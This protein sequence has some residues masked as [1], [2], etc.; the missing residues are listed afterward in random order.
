MNILPEN[1]LFVF[2]TCCILTALFVKMKFTF[3]VVNLER[4]KQTKIP[5]IIFSCR[6]QSMG[7]AQNI[8][9]NFCRFGS[10]TLN[11]WV[12]GTNVPV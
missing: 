4:N 6:L 10:R 9:E 11:Q 3:V 8:P 7:S 1:D 2:K 5:S 12:P